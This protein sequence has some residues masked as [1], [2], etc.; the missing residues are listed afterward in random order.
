MAKGKSSASSAT[1]KKQAAKA[2]KKHNRVEGDDDDRAQEDES[3]V[4]PQQPAQRGQKNKKIKKDRFAPKVKSYVPP[5][6]PPKGQPDPVDLY[7]VNQGTQVDPELVVILRKLAKKDEATVTKGVEGLEQWVR[8]VLD[9]EASASKGQDGEE[10]EWQRQ[11]KIDELIE[12]TQVWVS[13]CCL[14][15]S[16]DRQR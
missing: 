7:L 14:Q 12:S 5:P 15:T 8:E 1:R 3:V 9:V 6:P 10:E 2:A 4:K 13:S 16:R 11:Q